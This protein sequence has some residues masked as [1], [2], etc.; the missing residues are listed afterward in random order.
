MST[1]SLSSFQIPYD[2]NAYY[3]ES[4]ALFSTSSRWDHVKWLCQVEN[5]VSVSHS[6]ALSAI[7]KQIER[8]QKIR[9]ENYFHLSHLFQR[10]STLQ[11]KRHIF[12]TEQKYQQTL[13]AQQTAS[14][15]FVMRLFISCMKCLMSCPGVRYFYPPVNV[16]SNAPQQK[17]F[18]I[19][20][21]FL[22]TTYV[23]AGHFKISEE[24]PTDSTKPLQKNYEVR[25]Y[26]R[27]KDS[28][29]LNHLDF[30]IVPTD[31]PPKITLNKKS[32][33]QSFTVSLPTSKK[34]HQE[35][36]KDGENSGEEHSIKVLCI[37]ELFFKERPK[38]SLSKGGRPL[39]EKLTQVMVEILI[40]NRWLNHVMVVETY[41]ADA[42]VLVAG[43]FNRPD[44]DTKESNSADSQ[45]LTSFLAARFKERNVSYYPAF[46]NYGLHPMFLAHHALEQKNVYYGRFDPRSWNDI[47]ETDPILHETG[48]MLPRYAD[49]QLEDSDSQPKE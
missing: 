12:L 31:A 9:P 15:G 7:D 14:L 32:P 13:H 37:K 49:S 6:N 35:E 28:A 44:G 46:E 8:V 47:R 2:T 25:I 27:L 40:Q 41:H 23:T 3:L 48:G 36:G 10:F 34:T 4:Q 33:Y 42:I 30:F 18:Q 43:G 24:S 38:G 39:D 21:D 29:I 11:V 16:A 26:G 17:V 5:S 22:Q 19:L 1:P 45:L 20:D